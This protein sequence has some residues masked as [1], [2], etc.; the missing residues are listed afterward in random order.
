MDT[1]ETTIYHAVLIACIS[2]GLILMYFFISVIRQQRENLFLR[3]RNLLSEIGGM[4]KDRARI[5]A[6]LHDELGPLLSTVKIII[7]SFELSDP[8]D[9]AERK[10]AS[11]YIDNT[12]KRLRGISFNL[13]P[14]TL[15]KNGLVEAL[16]EYIAFLNQQHTIRFTLAAEDNFCVSEDKS[17]NIYRIIQEATYNAIKHSKATE[18]SV[19]LQH[20]NNKLLHLQISDNGIGFDYKRKLAENGGIGL[21]SLRNRAIITGGRMFMESSSKK[22]T[23]YLFEIPL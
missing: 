6:D 16:R 15:L 17:V 19:S 21:G 10:N 22:G 7:N 14:A 9:V 20:K 4:E 8:E 18:I 12:I 5:A 23:D 2:I 13:M 3:K 11:L 1:T